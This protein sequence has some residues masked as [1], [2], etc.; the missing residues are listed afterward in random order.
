MLYILVTDGYFN[1]IFTTYSKYAFTVCKS[2]IVGRIKKYDFPDEEIKDILQIAFTKLFLYMQKVD[3]VDN[4]K[5]LLAQI[6]ELS[7]TNHLEK[8]IRETDPLISGFT[9]KDIIGTDVISDPVEIAIDDVD[10]KELITLIKKLDVRYSSVILLKHVHNMS[11]KEI[12]EVS[13]IK[14]STICSWHIRGKRLLAQ[15][16][17]ERDERNENQL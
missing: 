11:L 6:V 2:T 16:L 4:V 9:E 13:E 5:S 17:A 15:M 12:S 10:F 1:E 14:Y 8:Y 3:K 7:T